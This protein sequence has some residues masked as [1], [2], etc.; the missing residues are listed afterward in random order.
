[1]ESDVMLVSVCICTY[2]RPSVAATINSVL[3]QEGVSISDIEIL[4]C[5]EDDPKTSAEKLIKDIALH[6][7]APIRYLVSSGRSIVNC[8]NTLLAGATGDWIAF[9]DDDQTANPSWLTELLSAQKQYNADVVKSY[10]KAIYPPGAPPWVQECD[11][12][13]RDYGPTGTRLTMPSTNGILFR[14]AFALEHNIAFDPQY[15]RTGGEDAD[16]FLRF[17]NRG[18]R[19]IACRTS[20]VNEHVPLPRLD[21]SYLRRRFTG[22]G[23]NYGRFYLSRLSNS[24]RLIAIGKSALGVGAFASYGLVWPINVAAG[25]KMFRKFWIY[26]G[27][28]E[29]AARRRSYEELYFRRRG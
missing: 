24:R 20:V 22:D 5:D 18:A 6:A 28:L 12:Y 2:G 15:G 17:H 29:W 21:K 11:P 13:T 14:R 16:F 27:V 8:R 9:I 3:S 19:I 10:V 26:L 25:F 1:M 7:P 4:V 23:Y